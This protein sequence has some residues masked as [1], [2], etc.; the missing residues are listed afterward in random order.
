MFISE[1]RDTWFLK[2]PK[3]GNSN[4]LEQLGS[5]HQTFVT[6]SHGMYPSWSISLK[7][8]L[9]MAR[10]EWCSDDAVLN[11]TT[12]QLIES[13]LLLVPPDFS[14]WILRNSHA[15]ILTWKKSLLTPSI[16]SGVARNIKTRSNLMVKHPWF[17]DVSW[18]FMMFHDASCIWFPV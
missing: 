14:C 16:F 7:Y 5:L 10:P 13:S 9:D 12:G 1:S 8:L 4:R 18:C 3:C 15:Q 11:G 2:T 6:S 17:H